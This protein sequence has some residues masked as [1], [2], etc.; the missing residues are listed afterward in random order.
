MITETWYLKKITKSTNFE[1][2][3]KGLKCIIFPQLNAS[4]NQLK[5][6]EWFKISKLCVNHKYILR[7]YMGMITCREQYAN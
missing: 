3:K 2:V 4:D 7:Y 5:P 6:I 1:M